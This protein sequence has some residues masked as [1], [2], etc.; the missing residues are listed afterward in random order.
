MRALDPALGPD[1]MFA[2]LRRRG[3]AALLLDGRG[4]L[5][6]AWPC[7]IALEPRL[8][9]EP[10]A[11]PAPPGVFMKS[12]DATLMRRRAAGGPGGTGIALICAYEAFPTGSRGSSG[13]AQLLA[14][15]VDAAVVF[16][17]SGAPVALG[18]SDLVE[19]AAATLDRRGTRAPELRGGALAAG[20]PRTSLAR[21]AYIRAVLRIKEHI[22]RGDVYQANLTQ[23]FDAPFSGDP[24]ELYRSI[25]ASNP[26][27]RSAYLEA[28]GIALAS[29]SP[30]IFVDVDRSGRAETRPIKGTR[31]RG[32]TAAD[33]AAA[34]AALLGSA[35]DRAELVMIVDVLRNDLG[36]LARTGGVS[37]PELLTLRSYAAVHHLVA[38]VVADLR[39]GL[40]PSEIVAA[41]FPGGSITGAPKERAIEILSGIEPCPRGFYTGSLFWFDDDGSMASSILIRSA[42]VE[43]GRVSVGAG[44]GVVADS[45]PEAEWNEANAK[46]RALTRALGFDPEE[47]T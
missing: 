8:L 46:A 22:E 3:N 38:R 14:L 6:G 10:N 7:R 13:L 21:D 23:R 17:D 15:E 26:A 29:V 16:P 44:G 19:R 32:A 12:L 43:G 39:E 34:A 28:A 11:L 30:E 18:P 41:V 37:V 31:P 20:R 25:A 2:A 42:V 24:W 45:E 9:V 27:P 40:Q 35:K 5:D 4:S 33:D 47:A 1:A 36:R